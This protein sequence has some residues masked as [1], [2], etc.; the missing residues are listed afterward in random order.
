MLYYRE[1]AVEHCGGDA[2]SLDFKCC[3]N[4]IS[5]GKWHHYPMGKKTNYLLHI[6][7]HTAL[8]DRLTSFKTTYA[9]YMDG[10]KS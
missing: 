4:G 8:D 6:N 10:T 2:N 1:A 9:M 3:S 7:A 5:F